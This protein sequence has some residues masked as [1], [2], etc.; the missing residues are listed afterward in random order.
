MCL[1]IS[2]EAVRNRGVKMK[3]EIKG[4]DR[5]WNHLSKNDG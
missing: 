2:K 1:R 3:K 5:H 4:G